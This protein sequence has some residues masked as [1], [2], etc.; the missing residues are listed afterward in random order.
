MRISDWSSDVCSSDLLGLPLL[1]L[2]GDEP[3]IETDAVEESVRINPDV[4]NLR[5][6]LILRPGT[7]D[8]HQPHFLLLREIYPLPKERFGESWHGPEEARSVPVGVARIANARADF[9]SGER[10]GGKEWCST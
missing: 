6:R 10:S 9:R 8:Q 3:G 2:E 7:C 4:A 1:C 5:H